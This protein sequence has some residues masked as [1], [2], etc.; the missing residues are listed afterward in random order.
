MLVLGT[1]TL[2]RP[3]PADAHIF[4]SYAEPGEGAVITYAPERVALAFSGPVA[5]GSSI[6]VI[7]ESGNEVTAGATSRDGD[8]MWTTLQPLWFGVYTVRWTVVSLDDGHDSSG[9][10]RF[11]IGMAAEG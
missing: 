4:L 1:V 11:T 7:D 5:R 2:L 3:Q 9:E 10:Y 6:S 8:W